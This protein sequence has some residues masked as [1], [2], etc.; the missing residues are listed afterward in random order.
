MLL[1][2]F[3]LSDDH[4]K[5]FALKIKNGPRNERTVM[6]FPDEREKKYK[7]YSSYGKRKHSFAEG[8]GAY[9]C[10]Y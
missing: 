1:R 10:F 4:L 5:S 7:T 8:N 2:M 3:P 9:L 6:C